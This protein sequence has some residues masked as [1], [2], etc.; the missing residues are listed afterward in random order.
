MYIREFG[1][2]RLLLHM[3]L[4]GS[5]LPRKLPLAFASIIFLVFELGKNPGPNSF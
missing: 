3:E 5:L 1:R 2:K 4:D